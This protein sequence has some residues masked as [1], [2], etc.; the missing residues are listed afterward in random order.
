MSD[1]PDTPKGGSESGEQ[2]QQG[3]GAGCCRRGG[4]GGTCRRRSPVGDSV[5][6]GVGMQRRWGDA[7]LVCS[8]RV[9]FA[10]TRSTDCWSSAWP[11]R[12][13]SPSSSSWP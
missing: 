11:R 6:P 4:G 1:R 8:T 5:Q 12:Q 3:A 10:G 9:S 2:Y 7:R 13:W